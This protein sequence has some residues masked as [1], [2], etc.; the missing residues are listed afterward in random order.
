MRRT[1][2]AV[3]TSS[4]MLRT[5]RQTDGPTKGHT[6]SLVYAMSL[7]P[8]CANEI[9][10]RIIVQRKKEKKSESESESESERESENKLVSHLKLYKMF[11]SV[12]E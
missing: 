10:K 7:F 3:M 1:P 9:K 5:H 2:S 11:S 12:K 6:C 8:L 4:R